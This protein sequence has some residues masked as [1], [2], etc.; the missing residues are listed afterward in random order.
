MFYFETISFLDLINATTGI[1]SNHFIEKNPIID[2]FK[3]QLE[4][5]HKENIRNKKLHCKFEIINKYVH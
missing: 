5:K 2:K 3:K 4:N 1:P